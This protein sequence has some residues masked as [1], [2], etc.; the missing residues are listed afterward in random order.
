M[1]LAQRKLTKAEWEGIEIPVSKEEYDVLQL[2]KNGFHDT[3]IIYN[4]TKSLYTYMK[5]IP[6]EEMSLFLFEKYFLKKIKKLIDKYVLDFTIPSSKN[7]KPKKKDI[8]RIENFDRSF[9]SEKK[10]IFEFI[11]L[12]LIESLLKYTQKKSD[13]IIL[14]YYTIY[15]LNKFNISNINPLFKLFIDFIIQTYKSSI[16]IKYLIEKSPLVIEHNAL[17]WKHA[18][19]SLY[20]HQKNIFSLFK[21]PSPKLVLY[22][23]PTATGKT[24]TPIGLAETYKIIFVCA[25]RH[26]GLA[27]AKSAIS[28]GRKIALA[29]NCGDAE[30]IRLHFSAAKDFTRNRKSGEIRKVDNTNGINVE[31]II[32]DIKSYLPAMYYMLAFNSKDKIITYWDEP[33]ITMDYQDHPFHAI[34]QKNWADNLIPNIVLSSATLPKDEEIHETIC[35][36][37]MRF[38]G[39]THTIISHD[40]KKTIPIIQTDCSIYL[41][42]LS[43]ESYTDMLESVKH[44]QNNKT[45]LRYLDLSE[46][47]R[48]VI[49]A[50]DNQF[51]KRPSLEINHYFLSIDSINMY[52]I[53]HYYL[54]ILQNIYPDKWNLLYKYFKNN[55]TQIHESNINIVSSDAYT[56]TDGPTIF[57]A[58]DIDKIAKFYLKSAKIPETT[59]QTLLK[60]IEMNTSITTEIHKLEKDYEDLD[61]RENEKKKEQETI[62]K[63]KQETGTQKITPEMKTI[64]NKI[65]ILVSKIK[66]IML[67]NS[68]IPNKKA[69]LDKWSKDKDIENTFTSNISEDTIIRI[70]KLTDIQATWKILLIMGIGVFTQHSSIAYTEIMKELAESQHLFMIVASSDYIYGTNY[71]F[72]HGYISKDLSNM[73]QEKTIQAMGRIGRNKMQQQYSIRFRN[74]DIIHKLFIFQK[75]RP[76]VININKLFIS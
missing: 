48:F 6:T 30:D 19:I 3:S 43:F 26:V 35:D 13:K 68:Y 28:A 15:N 47:V 55:T 24:L 38:A 76:E 46:I 14:N 62:R 1:D 16:N 20:K 56:L 2:I 66:P 57:M 59:I 17:L 5:I 21:S 11:V 52:E 25:A 8:I 10:N 49:Y 45:L 37:R 44:I 31:I 73:T 72:C 41:P 4:N 7:M 33:T 63:G 22:I 74:D 40:C 65:N 58:N 54:L 34:I 23:A 18:N 32:S 50:S 36:Y 9:E 27:L 75:H 71:Q 29:F 39:D 53:K 67:D 51:I 12:Q 64:K 69:H 61:V 60:E 70:A 42:H